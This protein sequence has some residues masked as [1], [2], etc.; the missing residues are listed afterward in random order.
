MN[1]IANTLLSELQYKIKCQKK[2]TQIFQVLHLK[3]LL[4]LESVRNLHTRNT[5]YKLKT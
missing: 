5:L 1:Q 2:I 4:S 3:N